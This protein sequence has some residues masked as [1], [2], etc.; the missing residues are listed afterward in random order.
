MSKRGP[1]DLI[2]IANGGILVMTADTDAKKAKLDTSLTLGGAVSAGGA[3]PCFPSSTAS[4]V[5]NSS[6]AGIFPTSNFMGSV[7]LSA[8]VVPSNLNDPTRVTA[9]NTAIGLE[10]PAK[11]RVV[12]LRNIPSDLTEFELLHFCIP[13]GRIVNHLLLK[14]KNQA[15]VEYGTL[16]DAQRIVVTMDAY[17]HAIRGRTMFV[18]YSTHQELKTEVKASSNNSADEVGLFC[19][20]L[21]VHRHIMLGFT[22]ASVHFSGKC[23]PYNDSFFNFPTCQK[24]L[25]TVVFS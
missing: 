17:P 8:T 3:S 4:I 18:Q 24:V 15:F 20:C 25:K 11:S 23:L 7:T 1:N 21:R 12:H 19:E 16:E 10:A 5:S 14:G 6:T 13:Y 2:P 22:K 9:I